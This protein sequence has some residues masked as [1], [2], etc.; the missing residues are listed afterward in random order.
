MM[1][2]GKGQVGEEKRDWHFTKDDDTWVLGLRCEIEDVCE[3]RQKLTEG[4]WQKET[5]HLAVRVLTVRSPQIGRFETGHGGK[6]WKDGMS[7][8]QGQPN[9]APLLSRGNSADI[10]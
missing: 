6:K 8:R 4:I 7:Q 10:L 5:A 2:S 9:S 3:G 1:G